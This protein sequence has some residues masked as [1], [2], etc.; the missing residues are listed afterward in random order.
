VRAAF[1]VPLG[2]ELFDQLAG[3]LFGHAQVLG[4][5]AHRRAVVGQAGEGEAVRRAQVGEA[6]GAHARVDG[7]HQGAGRVE[8][9]HRQVE[10]I[11]VHGTSLTDRSSCLT[12]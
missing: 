6:A 8:Q 1:H 3:R 11:T 5:L 12:I 9:Q 7:V 2:H 4:E 10:E